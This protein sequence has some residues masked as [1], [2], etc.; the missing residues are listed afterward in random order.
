MFLFFST[1]WSGLQM[2]M[3]S[4]QEGADEAAPSVVD[5]EDQDRAVS[6]D[7][8][9]DIQGS[10][11]LDIQSIDIR[12]DRPGAGGQVEVLGDTVKMHVKFCIG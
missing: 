10:D 2:Y 1:L 6:Q 5:P 8:P 11:S 3:K 7:K 12:A 4:M 9:R